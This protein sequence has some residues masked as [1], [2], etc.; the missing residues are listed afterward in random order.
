VKVRRAYVLKSG[1]PTTTRPPPTCVDLVGK[2][3]HFERLR[4]GRPLVGGPGGKTW[5]GLS[6]VPRERAWTRAHARAYRLP[7]YTSCGICILLAREEA[8]KG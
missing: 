8:A 1:E 4:G 5:C 2:R 7:P 6:F 3:V